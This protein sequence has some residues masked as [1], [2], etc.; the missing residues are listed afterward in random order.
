MQFKPENVACQVH[1]AATAAQ[2][3]PTGLKA[4][5]TWALQQHLMISECSAALLHNH[6]GPG[7][8]RALTL[9]SAPLARNTHCCTGPGTE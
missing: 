5:N 4:A 7:E 8:P 1:R 3:A 6:W 2:P 9:H